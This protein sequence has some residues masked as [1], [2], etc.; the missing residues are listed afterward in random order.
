M[1]NK[2]DRL[3]LA[4]AVFLALPTLANADGATDFL[5]SLEGDYAGRG[6][7]ML[8]GEKADKIACKISN[9]FD[10]AENMLVL[11][12]ECAST[13]GKDKIKGGVTTVNNTFEGAFVSPRNGMTITQNSGRFAGGKMILSV[14]MIEKSSGRLVRIQQ[15]ISKSGQNIQAKFLTYDNATST[16]KE[17]GDITLNKR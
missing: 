7:A 15:I 13:K 2:I 3:T 8:I 6:K 16:Y 11:D 1:F 4:T 9:T 10:E 12:G 14:S 5:K 17:S